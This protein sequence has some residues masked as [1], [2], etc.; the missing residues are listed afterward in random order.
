MCRCLCKWDFGDHPLHH[1]ICRHDIAKVVFLIPYECYELVFPQQD[2]GTQP[3]EVGLDPQQGVSPAPGSLPPCLAP[4]AVELA[5]SSF[6]NSKLPQCEQDTLS[7]LL[8]TSCSDTLPQEE[9][10]NSK[11][12]MLI[13]SLFSGAHIPLHDLRRYVQPQ[14]EVASLP[15]EI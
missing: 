13:F 15:Q 9:H 1:V 2:P 5:D 3:C 12:G 14:I 4:D 11:I 7:V 8:N 6:L 10:R